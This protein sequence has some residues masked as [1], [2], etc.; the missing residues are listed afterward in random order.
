MRAVAGLLLLGLIVATPEARYFR[1]QRPLENLPAQQG[2]ACVALDANIFAQASAGLADVRLYRDGAEVPY[3]MQQAEPAVATRGLVELLNKGQRNGQAVFDAE[4]QEGHYSDLELAVTRKDFIA[5]VQVSGSQVAGASSPTRLG[6]FTIFDL[7]RQKLGRST[8]LH[9]PESDF[10]TLHFQIAGPLHPDEVTGL[11]VVRLPVSRPRFVTVGETAQVTQK[12]HQS[13][14][15]IS[16]SGRVPV[17]RVE[18]VVGAKPEQFSRSVIIRVESTTPA[19]TE[20]RLEEAPATSSGNLLRV[21]SEQNGH[22]IDEENLAVAAPSA[23]FDHA[24]K[25]TVAVDNGDDPPLK[26][27][28]V[29]LEMV[30]RDLCFDAEGSGQYLLA[31]GDP[32]LQSPRYDYAT[33]FRLQPNRARLALGAQV[34][35]AA[36]QPRPD[37]RPLTER[38]PALLWSALVLVVGL[39]GVIALRSVKRIARP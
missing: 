32:A 35:N 30:E 24:A 15:A 7:S 16:V 31:Y 6:A 11:S 2:Q 34:A 37:E 25:Y 17:D 4:L 27:D 23:S 33:L 10:R 1:Y 28:A 20:G 22:R 5:T 19:S 13:I 14:F 39:L 18:F 21:H 29:R 3:A 38:Y 9:L 8:V 36:Y 12:D 26:I